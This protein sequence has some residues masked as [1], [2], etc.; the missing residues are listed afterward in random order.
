MGLKESGLEILKNLGLHLCCYFSDGQKKRRRV[1]YRPNNSDSETLK[2]NH[3]VVTWQLWLDKQEE[4]PVHGWAP[5]KHR[6]MGHFWALFQLFSPPPFPPP[7]FFEEFW[8]AVN[9][10]PLFLGPSVCIFQTSGLQH[11]GAQPGFLKYRK[12]LRIWCSQLNRCNYF[13]EWVFF[14]KKR[15]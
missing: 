11:F 5:L 7:P 15:P 9:S 14:L 8:F 12:M 6:R 2:H 13:C 4:Q 10:W 3:W 1:G